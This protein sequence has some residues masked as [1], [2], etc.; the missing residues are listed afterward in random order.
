MFP[1]I[2]VLKKEDK[3]NGTDL[4]QSKADSLM[5]YTGENVL[6]LVIVR[7]SY[8]QVKCIDVWCV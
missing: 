3:E 7:R 8:E 1:D 2:K 5:P 4:A 6:H